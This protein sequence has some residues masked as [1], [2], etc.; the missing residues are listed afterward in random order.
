LRR[1]P[2]GGF[3]VELIVISTGLIYKTTICETAQEAVDSQPFVSVLVSLTPSEKVN[4]E[5]MMRSWIMRRMDVGI[6]G[7][8]EAAIA[9]VSGQARSRVTSGVFSGAVDSAMRAVFVGSYRRDGSR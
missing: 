1:A 2:S 8:E 5:I 6:R 7:A 9:L 3:R 4:V